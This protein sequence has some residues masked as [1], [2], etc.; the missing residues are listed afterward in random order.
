MDETPAGD[1]EMDDGEYNEGEYDEGDDGLF[2]DDDA[3]QEAEAVA[4]RLGDA[5]WADISKAYAQQAPIQ[6]VEVS[7]PMAPSLQSQP[8]PSR[9][10]SP[11]VSEEGDDEETLVNA[12]Q[13]ILYFSTDLPSL[14][15]ILSGTIVPGTQEGTLLDVLTEIAGSKAVV[16]ELAQT[17]SDL[18]QSVADGDF[19]TLKKTSSPDQEQGSSEAPEKERLF[20]PEID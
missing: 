4:K 7:E 6:P 8:P 13:M 15:E 18:V 17:L 2:Y 16:P 1:Q 10:L 11:V 9:S 5:L 12:V 14:H 3:D 19:Y 20:T